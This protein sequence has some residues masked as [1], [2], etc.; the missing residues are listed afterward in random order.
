M[1]DAHDFR[2]PAVPAGPKT[3]PFVHYL[4]GVEGLALLRSWLVGDAAASAAR[5]AEAAEL[6]RRWSARSPSGD[7]VVEESPVPDGYETWSASY[8]DS[9]NAVMVL[10]DRA[11]E[12]ALSGIPAGRALD[13]ACGT[14]RQGERLRSLGHQVVGVDRSPT[15]LARARQ[16]LPGS[17]LV[18]ADMGAL[19]FASGGFDVVTC[20]LGLA[21]Q[22][23]LR[24][25]VG[26]IG[27]LLRPGGHAILC[28][29]HPTL[30]LLGG[31]AVVPLGEGRVGF[32]RN[33]HHSHSAYLKAFAEHRL[34]VVD[35]AEP[36]FTEEC[37]VSMS[38]A[39]QVPEAARA[40]FTGLPAVLMWKL[41]RAR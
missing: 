18:V 10:A 29:V 13:V 16:Q 4:L 34:D 3:F 11:L 19:P 27:R 40:A 20:C 35:S 22:D 15:M 30:V 9:P 2:E 21:H 5:I 37:R 41:R 39:T 14:G 25:A 33:H 23:D 32:V 6:C 36:V 17:G 38:A 1:T 12:R 26:E 24:R 28:D 8:D 7:V 31:H